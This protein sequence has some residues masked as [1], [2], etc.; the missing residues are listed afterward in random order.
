[1]PRVHAA[2]L[3]LVAFSTLVLVGCT[4]SR[5]GDEPELGTLLDHVIAAGA[6][7]VLVVVREDGKVRSE[8]RGFADRSRS[9][10]MRADERFRIGS[11]T[12]TFV[13]SLV[14]LLVEDGSLRLND[15]VER[16]LPGLVPAGRAITVRHLLSHTA[17]LFDYVEDGRVL[18]DHERRWRPRE[19]VSI[20]VAHPPER[21]PP[22][23]SFAYSSTNYLVLG[24]IVEEA[25]GAS[26]GQQ[27]EE[28]SLRAT[29]P[30]PN[31]LRPWRD[32]RITRARASAA[33]APRRRYR[34]SRRY[35]R[36]AR[37][38]D[39]GG[40]RDRL[41]RGRST[42]L[43]CRSSAWTS[44]QPA[45]P[46]RDGDART[47]WPAAVRPRNRHL[48]DALRA[49]MGPYG[50]RPGDDRRRLEHKGRVASARPRGEH[51]PALRRTRGGGATPPGWGILPRWVIRLSQQ[52]PRRS[53]ALSQRG[54]R[55]ACGMSRGSRRVLR[56]RSTS[57]SQRLDTN[58]PVAG[59]SFDD[60]HPIP[61]VRQQ[62]DD[63]RP[64]KPEAVERK[65]PGGILDRQSD[66]EEATNKSPKNMRGTVSH[67]CSVRR[68]LVLRGSLEP[69]VPAGT[70]VSWSVTAVSRLHELEALARALSQRG[71][72]ELAGCRQGDG[73]FEF[74]LEAGGLN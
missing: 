12:K 33:V 69:V 50:E 40:R 23:G 38:V 19:L 14:L 45:A 22:G 66:R 41:D 1:M 10:R 43:L 20:A 65:R 60:R 67:G 5:S 24:L 16:W 29:R 31:E 68:P 51:V 11:I 62:R 58:H 30:S 39:V 21:S 25:G 7:G 13:A 34:S 72:A 54:V 27:L 48:P 63:Q 49:G 6:P 32:S 3:I 70:T 52:N 37:L 44:A 35:E 17:G 56:S 55:R 28:P 9:L 61:A 8:A 53:V 57:A 4:G 15:T 26:L 36:R 74:E 59:P 18:R 46:A 47:G 64:E 71:H 73:E 42:P 2:A